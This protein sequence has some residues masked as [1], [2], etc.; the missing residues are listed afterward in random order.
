MLPRLHRRCSSGT[1]RESWGTSGMTSACISPVYTTPDRDLYKPPQSLQLLPAE[2]VSELRLGEAGG[3]QA[4][5]ALGPC[6][7]S[8]AWL[9]GTPGLSPG[10]TPGVFLSLFS[11][12]HTLP[13]IEIFPL[14]FTF[15]S[16]VFGSR[17]QV[18]GQIPYHR[19]SR[20]PV[21]FFAT[22]KIYFYFFW[23]FRVRVSQ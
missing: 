7:T 22:K 16:E 1:W 14:S 9:T 2:K 12:Y 18:Q 5:L 13:A 11:L 17:T 6:W 10:L 19:V 4:F 8:P 3:G 21:L 20:H 15:V 23:I